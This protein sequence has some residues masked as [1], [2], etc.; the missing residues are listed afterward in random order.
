M[1]IIGELQLLFH[2]LVAKGEEP[3][4]CPA[5]QGLNYHGQNVYV[6]KIAYLVCTF[7]DLRQKTTFIEVGNHV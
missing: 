1:F 2:W 6:T 5:K 7:G 4:H 3:E